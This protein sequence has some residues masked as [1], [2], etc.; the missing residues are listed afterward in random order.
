MKLI[1][2]PESGATVS[3]TEGIVWQIDNQ[4]E[5]HP[6]HTGDRLSPGTL[7]LVEDGGQVELGD[8]DTLLSVADALKVLQGTQEERTSKEKNESTD[9]SKNAEDQQANQDSEPTS[10]VVSHHSESIEPPEI[11]EM[12]LTFMAPV[13]GF[14]L[15]REEER[16]RFFEPEPVGHF[17]DTTASISIHLPITTDN[18]VNDKESLQLVIS[19][20]VKNVEPGQPVQVQLLDTDNNALLSGT[21]VDSQRRWTVDFG[22]VSSRHVSRGLDD[23]TISV[24]AHTEDLFGNQADDVKAFLLDTITIVDMWLDPS[25]DSGV[26]PDD[27]ITNINKP[28]IDGKGEPG[29]V[30][31]LFDGTDLAGSTSVEANGLWRYRFEQVLPDGVHHLKAVATDKAGNTAEATLDITIDTKA[32]LDIKDLDSAG[33]TDWSSL[34]LEGTV[35]DVDDGRTVTITVSGFDGKTI[36]ATAVTGGSLWDAGPVDV[37]TFTRPLDISAEVEDLAGNRATDRLPLLG[38]PVPVHLNEAAEIGFSTQTPALARDTSTLLFSQDDLLNAPSLK[39]LDNGHEYDVTWR[40][41]GKKL[42]GEFNGGKPAFRMTLPDNSNGV[43]R[44]TQSQALR[45]PDGYQKEPKEFSLIY[46]KEN[47]SGDV[48]RAELKVSV[49]D[50]FP[51]VPNKGPFTIVEGQKI[52]SASPLFTTEEAGVDGARV[53]LVGGKALTTYQLETAGDWKDY[54]KIKSQWGTLYMQEEGA[55]GYQAD[56]QLNNPDP[57]EDKI[58]VQLMD[59]DQ[60]PSDF[61]L[62]LRITDGAP[63]ECGKTIL[64]DFGETLPT[65]G[66]TTDSALIC[67]TGSDPIVPEQSGFDL[68]AIHENLIKLSQTYALTSKGEKL[69]FTLPG[70]DLKTVIFQTTKGHKVAEVTANITTKSDGSLK[71]TADSLLSRPFDHIQLPDTTVK[72]LDIPLAVQAIDQDGTKA[73]GSIEYVIDNEEPVARGYAGSVT[74]GKTISGSLTKKVS[75]HP[76]PDIFNLDGGTYTLVKDLTGKGQPAS[77]IPPCKIT[78]PFG[79]LD[80]KQDG[81]WEFQASGGLVNPKGIKGC[82][83]YTM[84]DGDGDKASAELILN[85]ED[86]P[87]PEGGESTTVV[88]TEGT[89]SKSNSPTKTKSPEAYPVSSASTFLVAGGSDPLNASTLHFTPDNIAALAGKLASAGN[90]LTFEIPS[91]AKHLLIGSAGGTEVLRVELSAAMAKGIKDGTGLDVTAKVTLFR[92]L[93]HIPGTGSGIVTV[94]GSRIE[95]ESLHAQVSDIDGDLLKKPLQISVEVLD[96]LLPALKEPTSIILDETELKPPS[97][98]AGDG[99][100]KAVPGSDPLLKG[101]LKFAADQPGLKGLFSEGKPLSVQITDKLIQLKSQNDVVLQVSVDSIVH[102]EQQNMQQWRAELFMPIDQNKG[103]WPLNIR[104]QVSDFDQDVV[105]HTLLLDVQETSSTIDVTIQNT[106]MDVTEPVMGLSS[107]INNTVSIKAGSDPVVRAIFLV[108][109]TDGQGFALEESGERLLHHGQKI[110]YFTQ[111]D[112]SIEAYAVDNKGAKGDL[113]F[114]L[115]A[116]GKSGEVNIPPTH[117]QTFPFTVT[118]NS[119]LDHKSAGGSEKNNLNI[120]LSM[121]ATDTDGTTGES[122]ANLNIADGQLPSISVSGANAQQTLTEVDGHGGVVAVATGNITLLKGSDPTEIIVDQLKLKQNLQGISSDHWPV[123]KVEQTAPGHYVISRTQTNTTKPVLGVDVQ[124]DGKYILTL[125]D[126]LDHPK[127]GEDIID[128]PIPFSVVDFDGDKGNSADVILHV[129]DTIPVARDDTFTLTEDTTIGFS[130]KRALWRNDSPGA[131]RDYYS[132]KNIEYHGQ[133]V[134]RTGKNIVLNIPSGTLTVKKNTQW[135]FEA[136]DVIHGTSDIQQEV[137][138]VTLVDGDG[139]EAH[140]TLN[141]KIKDAPAKFQNIENTTVVEDLQDR[142]PPASVKFEINLGDYD[143]Q[144]RISSLKIPVADLQS[145]TLK[146]GGKTLVPGA[147]GNIVVPDSAIQYE[148]VAGKRIARFTGL[149]YTPPLNASDATLKGHGISL[150]LNAEVTSQ[151]ATEQ[152]SGKL[153][154][155]VKAYADDPVWET[156]TGKDSFHLKEDE[157]ITLAGLK[158][159]LSDKDK[160]ETLSYRIDSLP[161]KGT[162]KLGIKDLKVRDSIVAERIQDVRFIPDENIS[163]KQSFTLTAIATESGPSIEKKTAEVPHDIGLTI[164]GIAD[165][166]ELEVFPAGADPHTVNITGREDTLV[167]VNANFKASLKDLDTSEEL[168]VW[169]S[170]EPDTGPAGSFCLA[171]PGNCVDITP[172]GIHYKVSSDELNNLRY[173][174]GQDRSSANFPDVKLKLEAVSTEKAIDGV[175]PC[176]GSEQ[177]RSE[178]GYIQIKLKGVVDEPIMIP[179]QNWKPDLATKTFIGTSQ[180][181]TPL[182]LDMSIAPADIDSSESLGALVNIPLSSL[183]NGFFIT[184]KNGNKPPI[185]TIHLLGGQ[186]EIVYQVGLD[187]LKVGRYS[188][189]PKPDWAGVAT[190][191]MSVSVVEQDG[192]SGVFEYTLKSTFEPVVDTSDQTLKLMGK[193]VDVNRSHQYVSGGAPIIMGG[194]LVLGDS[195]KSE[196]IE[197]ISRVTELEDFALYYDGKPINASSPL[198]GQ[199]PAGTTVKQAIS[200]GKL[201]IVPVTGDVINNSYPTKDMQHSTSVVH[202]LI[203]DQQNG[204][205]A[206]K[207]IRVTLD[208]SWKG[209]VDGPEPSG[210]GNNPLEDTRLVVKPNNITVQGGH[211]DL[212]L[213]TITLHSTDKDKSEHLDNT[214]PWKLTL[215]DA[216]T[217]KPTQAEWSLTG[218][219][220]QM[221]PDKNNWL[222]KQNDLKG[223]TLNIFKD[224]EYLLRIGAMV[225]DM[226]DREERRDEIH[227]QATNTK[228]PSKPCSIGDAQPHPPLEGQE[229]QPL[230]LKKDESQGGVRNEFTGDTTDSVT[231][232]INAAENPDIAKI[233]GI[234]EKLW[235]PNGTLIAWIIKE[236]DLPSLMVNTREH[237]SGQLDIPVHI[238]A[239]KTDGNSCARDEIL[240]LKI[241][242]VPDTPTVTCTGEGDEWSEKSPGASYPLKLQVAPSDTD[243]SEHIQKLVFRTPDTIKL[244]APSGVELHDQGGGV[245]ELNRKDKEVDTAFNARLSQIEFIPQKG[246]TGQQAITL[247]STVVDSAPGISDRSCSP[248]TSIF[249]SSV[250]VDIKP[251]NNCAVLVTPGAEGMED[252]EIALNGLHV[253]LRDVKESLSVTLSGV[254]DGAVLLESKG[255]NLLPFNGGGIWQIPSRLISNGSLE[256][257]YLKP[258]SDFSGTI[259]LTLNSFT[260]DPERISPC[261]DK[262]DITVRVK[263]VG[264]TV[265]LVQVASAEGKE[266]GVLSLPVNAQTTDTYT[267]ADDHKETL[268]A[269]VSIPNKGDCHIWPEIVSFNTTSSGITPQVPAIR[270]KG[271]TELPLTLSGDI[272]SATLESQSDKLPELEI[273]PG[274]G[275]GQCTAQISVRS[276]D[277]TEGFTEGLGP[278]VRFSTRLAITPQPDKPE[279]SSRYNRIALAEG[280]LAPMMLSTSLVNPVAI[281]PQSPVGTEFYIRI[282]NIPSGVTLLAQD[283][284]TEIGRFSGN[285]WDVAAHELTQVVYLKGMPEGDFELTLNA[286]SQVSATEITDSDPVTVKLKVFGTGDAVKAP[287]GAEA[288]LVLG[289]DDNITVEGN[290][291]NNQIAGGSGENRIIG[292]PGDD[293]LWGGEWQGHGDGVKD[294]FVW[295]SGDSGKDILKDFEPGVDAIDLSGIL[296]LSSAWNNDYNLLATRVKLLEQPDNKNA[297]LEVYGTGGTLEQTIDLNVTPTSIADGHAGD[298]PE[299]LKYMVD[300][301]TLIVLPP[302]Y[303]SDTDTPLA[304]FHTPSIAGLDEDHIHGSIFI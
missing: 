151:A 135:K 168:S 245:Y 12:V 222:V 120:K 44:F 235:N 146:A 110:R 50:D 52:K 28:L 251:I 254:P 108:P 5:R 263:P 112:T 226:G 241:C 118:D 184:D 58:P 228:Q 3:R 140:S 145:G 23:G 119:F 167:P 79:V 51:Q 294:V 216:G 7:L 106:A 198:S 234:W 288:Y 91:N 176:P 128:M 125:M 94:G 242:P 105:T 30:I 290:Q 207:N 236:H 69:D 280:A 262:S 276:V 93:D 86:G 195:D 289:A 166:P 13:A 34:P 193:E 250:T 247:D 55:W 272:A 127:R 134:P 221:F 274:D 85:I 232:R 132:L 56:E 75:A 188:F 25:S 283:K 117:T 171:E 154:I 233:D 1:T 205:S 67:K 102:P 196:H 161:D 189:Q 4:G 141:I 81:Q 104:L 74:E 98:V 19:G 6:L 9:K 182:V 257:L 10:Q 155:Q 54:Y 192:A 287:S 199:L 116:L 121:R 133:T 239:V 281:V 80:F 231:V 230:A 53:F 209:E 227:I 159:T 26:H 149:T 178:P 70:S 175:A 101:S 57:L 187:D 203:R 186:K 16:N 111:S 35:K 206:E 223:I 63:P 148:M 76:D 156:G 246:V 217:N 107:A 153:K 172:E 256:T 88:L 170:V 214:Y 252:S 97:P 248:K 15:F 14:S 158:A 157:T 41:E 212:G 47:P 200:N 38:N 84:T 163:G 219:S 285:N 27:D 191:K 103:S 147:D 45:H 100:V 152:L 173:K 124:P 267:D 122:S 78:F 295:N 218:A 229:D 43:I 95:I 31:R 11:V 89:L 68:P 18:I 292:G 174:P 165:E 17:V 42:L 211:Y 72:L 49:Q 185:A 48:S 37:S 301:N 8:A 255:G 297:R 244:T 83:E 249:N 33:P 90:P 298:L 142:S 259:T 66:Y 201:V 2:V 96:G 299:A 183:A 258:Q 24:R 39:V 99:S 64:R 113:V 260:Q 130:P 270:E 237:Y 291:G 215:L 92:P 243:G 303:L 20:T 225:S 265:N 61:F 286:I 240:Q 273:L 300:N 224:G 65:K 32:F 62:T 282:Q 302:S 129:V 261:V 268:R 202:T 275:F 36:T 210:G 293:I 82:V 115:P 123:N 179:S 181:D 150:K 180:E 253:N 109:E 60:D 269:S 284:A 197:D 169:L 278:E 296:A 137:F 279:L 22:S 40:I 144:E 266:N 277:K 136:K 220:G 160:S 73:K 126:N 194:K 114:T 238:K 162:L 164:C 59:Y 138:H 139:D 71:I 213:E 204:L 304:S 271:G 190:G 77:C 264:D 208:I 131:D 87:A 46:R 29:S 21:I 177:T 143:Q